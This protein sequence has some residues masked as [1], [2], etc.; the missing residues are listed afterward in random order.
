MKIS[1]VF[2][3]LLSKEIL[4]IATLNPD[5]SINLF[6]DKP[7]AS[8]PVLL[9]CKKNSILTYLAIKPTNEDGWRLALE[10]KSP[11]DHSEEKDCHNNGE[12]DGNEGDDKNS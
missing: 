9:I 8:N 6:L 2:S 5:Q 10:A 4:L 11:T 1:Q 7:S 12:N 3:K